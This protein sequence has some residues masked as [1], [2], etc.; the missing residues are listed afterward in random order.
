MVASDPRLA[1]IVEMYES[2]GFEVRLEP[3]DP[4][5]PEWSEDDCT[6]CIDDPAMAE[7]TKIVYTR[8][9]PGQATSESD[10]LFE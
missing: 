8:P 4:D 2:L 1:E 6:Y 3:V 10:E 9:R 5:D 7:A